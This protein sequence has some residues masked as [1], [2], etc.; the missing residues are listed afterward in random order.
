MILHKRISKKKT[1]LKYNK[2][3]VPLTKDNYRQI[4]DKKEPTKTE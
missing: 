4:L 1:L 3:L 2:Q